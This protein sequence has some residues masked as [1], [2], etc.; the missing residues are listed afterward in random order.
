MTDHFLFLYGREFFFSLILSCRKKI[1][2]PF[3]T[4]TSKIVTA[5]IIEEWKKINDLSQC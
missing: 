4:I 5:P 2:F 1:F 3:V